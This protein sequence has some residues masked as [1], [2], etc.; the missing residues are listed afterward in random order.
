VLSIGSLS[1]GQTEYYERKVARGMEDYYSGE[2]EAPGRWTGRAA[3]ALGLDGQV[4]AEQF[5]A[6]QRGLDPVS[7]ERLAERSGRSKVASLDLTFSAPKSL[8]TLFAIGDAGLAG[9]LVAA[10]EEAVQGALG[11]LEGVACQVR[12]GRNGVRRERA[13]GFVVAAYRHRMS[14]A[15]DPQLHTHCV[16]A[17]MARGSDG[18]WTA[19][20]AK[21]IYE[22][23]KAAGFVYQAHLRYAVCERLPWARWREVVNGMAELE[24]IPD[25]VLVE[26]SQRRAQILERERELVAAGVTVDHAG[27]E[28]IA[29]D[30]R[31]RKQ[32]GIDA[33]DWRESIK[34]RA[35]EHGL[36]AGELAELLSLAPV[37][38][39]APFEGIVGDVGERLAGPMGLTARRNTFGERD[40]VIA[41]A[42]AARQGAPATA[43]LDAAG[44][45]LASERLVELDPGAGEFTTQ[46]LLS[47]EEAI[48]ETAQRRRGEGCGVLDE[49]LVEDALTSLPVGLGDEQLEV[50]RGV[51]SSGHGVESIEAL[52]GTGK[53]TT[54]G[55]LREIYERG[56][57]TV[58]GAAP[59]GRALREL[60]EEAGIERSLTL[61][62]WGIKLQVEEAP[63]GFARGVLIVDEAG[64]AGT[65]I[66]APVLHAA[67]R[68]GVK[69][70]A[71]G[72][73]GQLSSV[74]AGG[75]LGSLT[76]R[77]GSWELREVMRQRDPRERRLLAHVHRGDPDAYI[78]HKLAA[79]ELHVS[80][81]DRVGQ[82]AEASAIRAWVQAVGRY[83]VEQAVLVSRNNDRRAGLNSQALAALLEA[84]QLGDGIRVA[85]REFWIGERVIARLNARAFDVDNGTRGTV[86]EGDELR[87]LVVV[88]D[89]G[90]LRELP[91]SYVFTNVEPAFCLT[92]HGM[93]G[94]TV[95]WAAVVGQP[96]EFSRNWSY[97]ACSRAR[98]PTQLFVIDDSTT[99]QQDRAQ[100]A[101]SPKRDRESMAR[102]VSRMRDRD[103]EDLALDRLHGIAGE[104][105]PSERLDEPPVARNVAEH[106]TDRRD[107]AWALREQLAALDARSRERSES[108]PG[109]LERVRFEL[110]RRREQLADTLARAQTPAGRPRLG[111]RRPPAAQEREQA[112]QL[113]RT[114]AEDVKRLEVQECS[115]AE[116][117]GDP[118]LAAA[119]R[120]RRV[121]LIRE[122]GELRQR[123]LERALENPAPWLRETL[124]ERPDAPIERHGWDRA[125]G[126][127]E[128]YRFE[129]DITD[130]HDPLGEQPAGGRQLYEY[131]QTLRV[132]D[133]AR[134]QLGLEPLARA[135]ERDVSRSPDRGDDRD[136]GF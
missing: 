124:G 6:L 48:V 127:I 25:G 82:A 39:P 57:Y 74:P 123:Q 58:L 24:Q 10:H 32:E 96:G 23:A 106:V 90:E 72:D 44:V 22:H 107:R 103:D 60:K 114:L 100:I 70:V 26:L 50:V 11:Y 95:D 88:T 134:L 99:A 63:L 97:T 27:R 109:R 69:V 128:T 83:G 12:R 47:Q 65:R 29:Y 5:A 43:L 105:V 55:A 93:Q 18:R 110:E 28:R 38:D 117:V 8:S 89:A 64:M 33:S 9:L 98:E 91:P 15:K 20:H 87:G 71:I 76:R 3:G 108:D 37:V 135:Q 73:S 30:T 35:A 61:D 4:S 14:R 131:E 111:R 1:V 51:T 113:A 52:A 119:D 133:D 36:G 40:A 7:G 118:D 80:V 78:E 112:Q 121:E 68:A 77:I 17:N 13:D 120:A 21:P 136:L 79:G 132:I 86:V 62:G 130:A 129:R 45:F 53:T 2:G 101:P 104:K 46:E 115:L 84:G 19:L 16:T 125:A 122:L 49:R 31:E 42:Q 126:A 75:W 66:T 116:R 56:G 59:T 54:A 81:G 34:V 92:G 41:F 102:L 67:A 94:G 85:G